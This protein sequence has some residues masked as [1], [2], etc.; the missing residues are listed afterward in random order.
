M[1]SDEIRT[2]WIP[3]L[4]SHHAP[5]GDIDDI[6]EFEDANEHNLAASVLAY[7]IL[8]EGLAPSLPTN[9]YDALEEHAEILSRHREFHDLPDRLAAARNG[10][11]SPDAS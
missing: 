11:A 1:T 2:V 3:W 8:E 6:K 4:E 9:L 7:L 5:A 10:G